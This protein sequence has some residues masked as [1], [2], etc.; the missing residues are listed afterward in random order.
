MFLL[1]VFLAQLCPDKEK[2]S[3]SH[4]LFS[5]L[6]Y[7]SENSSFSFF[8]FF[9]GIIL[10][11]N[12]TLGRRLSPSPFSFVATI[13]CYCTR[14]MDNFARWLFFLDWKLEKKTK[15]FHDRRRCRCRTHSILESINEIISNMRTRPR[16]QVP[17]ESMAK[18]QSPI[19]QI[20][21]LDGALRLNLVLMSVLFAAVRYFRMLSGFMHMDQVWAC[22]F[23]GVLYPPLKIIYSLF[24]ASSRPAGN[25]AAR[26]TP[27]PT[28]A[29]PLAHR[30]RTIHQL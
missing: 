17:F 4:F 10:H 2:I 21:S 18:K 28:D 29:S 11:T 15:F 25:I 22:D 8:A 23:R 9:F 12:S 27:I 26:Q 3:I 20:F 13:F 30:P 6:F 5:V 16:T 19:R 14:F 7:F 24:Q 1:L